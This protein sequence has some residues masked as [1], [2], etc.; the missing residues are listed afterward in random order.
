MKKEAVVVAVKYE[1]KEYLKR[2]VRACIRDGALMWADFLNPLVGVEK[3][4]SIISSDTRSVVK[5]LAREHSGFLL[6]TVGKSISNFAEDFVTN[7][8]RR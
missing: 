8:T 4:L 1:R 3:V 2:Y 5:D 7:R 6:N